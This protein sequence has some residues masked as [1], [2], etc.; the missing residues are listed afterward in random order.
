MKKLLILFF[1]LF[2]V[3][4]ISSIVYAEE[5]T[6]KINGEKLVTND[7][8][9]IIEGRTMVPVRAIF[10]GI[11]ANVKWDSNTKT[12]IGNKNDDVVIMQINNVTVM[13][14]DSSF[15]MDTAP[16]IVEDK[17]YAPVRYVAECYEYY[18]EWDNE[19][20]T[21][22]ISNEIYDKNTTETLT[23]TTTEELTQ[24]VTKKPFAEYSSKYE[25]GTYKGG[26]DIPA[27]EYMVLSKPGKFAKVRIY[28]TIQNNLSN[29]EIEKESIYIDYSYAFYIS[30]FQYVDIK[31]GVI[32]PIND[33]EKL[34]ITK[35]GVFR[36][37][38]DIPAGKYTFRLTPDRK[39]GFVG[40]SGISSKGKYISLYADDCSETSVLLPS[41]SIIE[42]YGVE[43][44]D[45]KLNKLVN[46]T[47][48][49]YI[50]YSYDNEYNFSDINNSF[51]E[52]VDKELLEILNLYSNSTSE[53][54]TKY[55]ESYANTIIGNWIERANNL[56]EKL[57]AKKVGN[58]Y[59]S[60][61]K[62]IKYTN[63]N[64]F[65]HN[66]YI[67]NNCKRDDFI[68]ITNELKNIADFNQ[69]NKICYSL[70]N[71]EYFQKR[72]DNL[73]DFNV[74]DDSE[75]IEFPSH[76]TIGGRGNPLYSQY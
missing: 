54:T 37:G 8:P 56:S 41:G 47:E 29:D 15:D 16:I 22:I 39:T 30:R 1:V 55:K 65:A 3:S 12:I 50:D 13:V 40:I 20:K 6:I 62:Y 7:N 14:N 28:N 27:G 66:P 24:A 76:N 46:R 49:F 60:F 32:I 2:I 17:A 9:I 44:Y 23:E 38:T 18:V 5:I 53:S 21:V 34:D 33:V 35:D 43:I 42:K 75:I 36:I 70:N 11:G 63:S 71:L 10:E 48:N 68:N 45:L 52:K 59:L 4:S 58:I 31:D 74:V 69:L 61:I 25:D 19:S 51:K 72:I 64:N 67:Y 73:I 57:Y 26:Y